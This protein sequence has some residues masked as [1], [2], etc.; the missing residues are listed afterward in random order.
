MFKFIIIM[1]FLEIFARLNDY[2]GLLSFLAVLAAIIVPYRIY[3]KQRKDE[4]Q[5]IKDELDAIGDVS[6]FPMSSSERDLYIR[7][8]LLE[9][10]LKRK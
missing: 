6:R 10:R 5:S 7:K 8:F 9:K 4:I 2:A 1:E 3:R